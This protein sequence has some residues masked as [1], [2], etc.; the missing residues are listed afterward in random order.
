MTDM[1]ASQWRLVVV[2][3]I[4]LAGSLKGSF[5]LPSGALANPALAVWSPDQTS[6]VNININA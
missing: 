6:S 5:A 1:R 4:Q 3:P 2:Y